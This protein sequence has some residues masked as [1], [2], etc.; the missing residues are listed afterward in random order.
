MQ[1]FYLYFWGFGLSLALT[2]A[3]FLIINEQIGVDVAIPLLVL[4][5]LVQL[6]VQVVCFLHL[7]D[8]KRPRWRL[9]ALLFA[10]VVVAIVVGG[11]LWIMSDMGH[12][13]HEVRTDTST[14]W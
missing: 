4:L 14:I 12:G 11:T 5:A 2:L 7:S 6:C 10:L 1:A 13:Q 3:A 9:M 8:E